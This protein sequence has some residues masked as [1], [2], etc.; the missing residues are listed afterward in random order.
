MFANASCHEHC[1]VVRDACLA[2]SAQIEQEALITG[3]MPDIT[4]VLNQVE[5]HFTEGCPSPKVTATYPERKNVITQLLTKVRILPS[6]V[7]EFDCRSP[8]S[9]IDLR[10]KQTSPKK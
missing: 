3:A 10:S 8:K 2:A 4:G 6:E 1:P 5:D 7:V 9:A